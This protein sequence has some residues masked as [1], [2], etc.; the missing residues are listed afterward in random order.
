MHN[1][2][3]AFLDIKNS[4]TASLASMALL[5]AWSI[6]GDQLSAQGIDFAQQR[7][8]LDR[9]VWSQERLAQQYD[10]VFIAL[11]DS[12]R[13]RPQAR[14]VLAEFAFDELILGSA[15][16]PS[17][18]HDWDVVETR[19]GNPTRSLDRS[20]WSALLSQWEEEGLELEQS[21]WHHERFIPAMDDDGPPRSQIDVTLHVKNRAGNWRLMISGELSVT[22]SERVNDT[23]HLVPAIIDASN[24]TLTE[25][26]GAPAFAE[27]TVLEA[28]TLLSPLIAADLDDDGFD[29]L[30]ATGSN[31]RYRNR[32]GHFEPEPLLAYPPRGGHVELALLADFTGDGDLDLIVGGPEQFLGFYEGDSGFPLPGRAISTHMLRHP[33]AISAGDIDADGDLDVWVGQYRIPYNQG[34]MPTPY[35]D[36][37]DGYIAYLLRN[38]GDGRFR[39][40]TAKAGLDAK[41]MR[42]TY[43]GSLADLDGDGDLDLLVV[44]DFSGI[45]LYYNDGTGSFTDVTSRVAGETASFGMSHAFGDYNADGR[46]DLYIAGMS[47]HTA[48]RLDDLGLGREEFPEHTRKRAPMSFGNRIYLGEERG[49]FSVATNTD[50]VA[51]TGWSWGVASSDF[52]NDG[53]DEIYVGNGHISGDSARDYCTTFWTHDVYTG[54]SETDPRLANYFDRLIDAW[55]GAGNSWNG[56]EHNKLYLNDGPSFVETGYLMGVAFQF[57]AR[58][59]L[60]M[61]I[62][63]DGRLDLLVSEWSGTLKRE[64]VHVLRNNW[65]GGN[66][67]LGV[68]LRGAPGVSPIGAR[69]TLKTPRGVQTQWV[70]TG[71]SFDSQH[72]AA[73]QFGLGQMDRVDSVEVRWPG[74]RVT[75][76][77]D[78]EINRYHDMRP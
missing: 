25:R 73:R 77:A 54:D 11:W 9:T 48:R 23:G 75:A 20:Q 41:R 27:V 65:P 39:D 4:I 37:N 66:N 26:R 43:S 42:R 17:T 61:D 63:N 68:R 21:E 47:S 71:E 1:L 53:D 10:A 46:L 70:Y 6:T 34:Q 60:D 58:T 14:S 44:S 24:L 33:K 69:I 32:G 38:D 28:E 19:F 55:Y 49:H 40:I 18:P 5:A 2:V 64:R 50:Q 72:S 56:F 31:L 3:R 36:A 76:V 59:V 52:D 8:E 74:G 78:P 16:T 7:L 45:D 35:Y 57:D 22:W 12:L 51:R 29:D 67:W 62:D 15:Q 30:L 13:A